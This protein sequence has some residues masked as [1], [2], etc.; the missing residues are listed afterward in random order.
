MKDSCSRMPKIK[1]LYF[2]FIENPFA[3]ETK[4]VLTR[5]VADFLGEV[6]KQ[7]EDI[8]VKWISISSSNHYKVSESELDTYRKDLGK[9]K[10][11][12][13]SARSSR[14]CAEKR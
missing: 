5:Q 14:D 7:E 1:L 11:H 10:I 8:E 4:G 9:Y 3:P 12:C 6:A 2:T 13:P